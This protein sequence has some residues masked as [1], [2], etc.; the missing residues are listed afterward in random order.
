MGSAYFAITV[1]S[2]FVTQCKAGLKSHI[3]ICCGH[4]SVRSCAFSIAILSPEWG[5]SGLHIP[6][7]RYLLL[8]QPDAVEQTRLLTCSIS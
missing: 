8:D 7:F 6:A 2:T 3:W 4:F 1:Y 5:C